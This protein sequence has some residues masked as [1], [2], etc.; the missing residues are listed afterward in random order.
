MGFGLRIAFA[1]SLLGNVFACGAI[2]GG[3]WVLERQ[4]GPQL[5]AAQGRPVRAAGQ[6]LPPADRLRFQETIRQ[7][8]VDGRDLQR[9]A[10]SDRRSAA[11]LFARPD[12]DASAVSAL[13]EQ[14]RT[15]DITLQSRIDNAAIGFA[16]TLP[17]DE[18]AILA[19]GL[20][21][22]GPLRHPPP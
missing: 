12:F 2:G 18:R 20:E 19:A 22:G 21:R 14:A 5:N 13:L 9:V 1:A 3:L 4:P 6:A 16:A 7:I 11:A 8:L 17:A 15:A 10:A